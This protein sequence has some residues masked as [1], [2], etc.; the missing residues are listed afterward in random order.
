[1]PAT[2]EKWE[3]IIGREKYIVSGEEMRVILN[4][5]E[6]RFVK[7]R[8]IVI[9]PAFVQS[10]VMIQSENSGKLEAPYEGDLTTEE[11]IESRLDL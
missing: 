6:N 1:M 11:W 7:F 3:V 8:D 2:S 5:G 10:M 9:N 4:A